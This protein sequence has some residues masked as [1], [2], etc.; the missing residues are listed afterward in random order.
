MDCI[1]SQIQTRSQAVNSWIFTRPVDIATFLGSA[2]VSLLLAALI[3]NAGHGGDTPPWLWLLIIVGIDV[4]H[5]WATIFRVYLDPDELAR[6]PLLYGTAPLLTLGAG[7]FAY[8]VS[9]AWFWRALAY[10]AV[11]HF[12][13]QQVGWMVLYG[14][15]AGHSA[16]Q[17]RLDR[18]LVYALSLGPV[19]W[20]HAHLP[21]PFWWFK[22]GDFMAFLPE[23]VG[24]IA[25]ALAVLTAALW[26]GAA[27]VQR[28][29][30]SGKLLFALAT[31][32]T[33]FGG[34]VLAP[35]DVTFTLVNVASHG[36]PYLVLSRCYADNRYRE[37]GYA[38]ARP[39]LR[40]GVASFLSLLAALAFAEEFFWDRL[41]WHEHPS[42]FGS[43]GLELPS[44][45]LTLV[46]PLLSVPQMTHYL[47]DGFIWR[48]RGDAALVSRL[49]W[50]QPGDPRKT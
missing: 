5:V 35:D 39:F 23:S 17:V 25:L 19:V 21:R 2:V 8:S 34:I 7:V 27:L 49:G 47:L 36:V 43:G 42:I 20:W 4:A 1:S 15:R 11:W 26:L 46:V 28:T 6:R 9:S 37:G 31:A 18:L 30:H 38:N 29:F 32:V 3:S 22:E 24:T 44:G 41:V 13:R 45:L 16:A 50:L 40:W 12:V 33:W 48:T 10:V 14:R